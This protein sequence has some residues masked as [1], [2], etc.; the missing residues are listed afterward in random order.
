MDALDGN[1]IAGELLDVFGA[2]RTTARGACAGCGA[3]AEVAEL[4]VYAQGA[5]HRGALP[6]AATPCSSSS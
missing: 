2:E 3:V 4:A 6:L 5:R 1:A